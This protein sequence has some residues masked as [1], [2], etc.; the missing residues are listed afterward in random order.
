MPRYDR[1]SITKYTMTH[2]INIICQQLT[3]LVDFRPDTGTLT[4][5]TR[6]SGPGIRIDSAA[7][8]PGS[9]IKQHYDSMILKC[10]SHGTD[11]E[12]AIQ[13]MLRA[14]GELDISGVETNVGFLMSVLQTEEI[15]HGK[16][17]TTFLEDT[18][19]LME[20][21][22]PKADSIEKLLAFLGDAVVNGTRVIGQTVRDIF[23]VEKQHCPA[24]QLCI[25]NPRPD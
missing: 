3:Q 18:P 23:P 25:R 13:T 5:F 21:R 16:Y 1:G 14:L 10:I 4:S 17:W 6:P 12:K 24:N 20:E 9:V 7:L 2:N 8:G 15:R 22:E 11:L 19:S